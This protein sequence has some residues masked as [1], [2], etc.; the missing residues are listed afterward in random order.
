MQVTTRL[1]QGLNSYFVETLR[2]RMADR[3]M[4]KFL[5]VRSEMFEANQ[6]ATRQIIRD[7]RD[8][9]DSMKRDLYEIKQDL[10]AVRV[11][12]ERANSSH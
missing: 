1:A 10:D 7:L 9:S 6:S 11:E 12:W 4:N 5:D 8:H 3:F 2:I